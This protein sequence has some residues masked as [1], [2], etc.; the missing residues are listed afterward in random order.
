MSK[1]SRICCTGTLAQLSASCSEKVSKATQ[2]ARHVN[3]KL[4]WLRTKM[5]KEQVMFVKIG[6]PNSDVG[7]ALGGTW[8][9]E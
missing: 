6:A 1:L 8:M 9:A 2:L 7:G 5:L 4:L 3:T